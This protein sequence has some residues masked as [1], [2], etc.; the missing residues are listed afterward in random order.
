LFS[1]DVV[2]VETQA[3]VTIHLY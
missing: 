2:K 1:V 3:Y